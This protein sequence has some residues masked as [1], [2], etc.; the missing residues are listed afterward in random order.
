MTGLK[1]IQVEVLK[2]VM[3]T[4]KVLAFTFLFLIPCVLSHAYWVWSPETGKFVN[5]EGSTQDT[6]SEQYDFA[7]SLYKDKKIDEAIDEL[8]NLLKKFRGSQIAPEA[9]YRLGAIYEEKN[10]Y[11]KA[12]QSYKVVLESYPQ[13][14]R[15]NE[16]IEREFRIGNL[17]L[18]GKKAKIMGLEILPSL[19]RAVEVFEHIIRQAPYSEY[20]DQAQFRL[21]IAYKKWGRYEDGIEA[22]QTLIDNYPRSKLVPEARFQLADTSF[23]KSNV[24][25]RDQKALESASSYVD[26]FLKRHPNTNVSEKAAKIRQEIDE[27]N[28][29]KNY[30]IGIYY[31]KTNYLQSALIYFEDVANRYPH[32][33]WGEKA[34]E[35][36]KTLQEPVSYLLDEEEVARGEI[37]DLQTQMDSI[38]E[39]DSIEKG[40]VKRQLERMKERLKTI[41]RSKQ[42]SMKSREEDIKRREYELG[43]KF[44]KLDEKRKLLKANQSED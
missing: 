22:F 30:S 4:R 34:A 32:T 36:L 20:G 19:P 41:E 13:S 33:R 37:A 14:E 35:K 18:S 23:V 40:R 24:T 3:K 25:A 5:P 1:I 43:L 17:F 16:V 12:F 9:Q 42:S 21:G 6:A 27:K 28:A 29:E 15:I 31:E 11:Y 39:K 8:K 44:K 38:Q 26:H 2:E 10:E 7:M